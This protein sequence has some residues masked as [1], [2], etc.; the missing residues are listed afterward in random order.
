LPPTKCAIIFGG[1]ETRARLLF[2]ASY[3]LTPDHGEQAR[4]RAEVAAFPPERVATLDD[5][6]HW[7]RQRQV[8]LEALRLYPPVP[9]WCAN[10]SKM[11]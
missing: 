2:W 11:T 5:V 9:I 8:L 1:Y 6:G 3:L 7:P 4:L 10:R